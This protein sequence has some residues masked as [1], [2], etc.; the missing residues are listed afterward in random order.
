MNKKQK[1]FTDQIYEQGLSRIRERL[2]NLSSTGVSNLQS[3]NTMRLI[4]TDSS[5]LRTSGFTGKL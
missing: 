2:T 5:Q 3:T 4:M 1:Q